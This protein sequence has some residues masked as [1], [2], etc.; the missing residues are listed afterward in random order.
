MLNGNQ[1]HL[2]LLTLHAVSPGAGIGITKK[3]G[4]RVAAYCWRASY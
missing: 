3:Y 4:T 1:S 2:Q